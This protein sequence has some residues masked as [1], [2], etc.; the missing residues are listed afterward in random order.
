M[1]KLLFL[2]IAIAL[3]GCAT[4]IDE[5]KYSSS[6]VI[7]AVN[8]AAFTTSTLSIDQQLQSAGSDKSG[9]VAADFIPPRKEIIVKFPAQDP[10]EFDFNLVFDNSYLRRVG[11][12]LAWGADL[13]VRTSGFLKD[14]NKKPLSITGK[15]QFDSAN[16]INASVIENGVINMV[17]ASAVGFQVTPNASAA[18]GGLAVGLI[19]GLIAGAITSHAVDQT[20]GGFIKSKSFAERIEQSSG[21]AAH[22]IHI[23][24]F[25]PQSE[26]LTSNIKNVRV[27]PGVYKF[28]FTKAADINIDYTRN[29]YIATAMAVYRGKKFEEEYPKTKGWDFTITNLNKIVV[30]SK[31]TA[32]EEILKNFKDAL[33]KSEISL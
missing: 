18:A 32:H 21:M 12:A 23:P 5:S 33:I 16:F 8:E 2:G 22:Q 7:Y 3:T 1:K 14:E 6:Q 25:Y 20:I 24:S 26:V 11:Q 10:K 27:A 13:E 17:S 4:K 9:Y 15:F 30:P 29:V 19:G 28:V 31:A